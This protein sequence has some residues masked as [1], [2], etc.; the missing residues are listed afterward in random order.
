MGAGG[1]SE[2]PQVS[3]LGGPSEK[4]KL[5]PSDKEELLED[6]VDK[7][8]SPITIH[9]K[10]WAWKG[11]KIESPWIDEYWKAIHKWLND[12]LKLTGGKDHQGEF[13]KELIQLKRYS[14]ININ[15]KDAKD[16]QK[17]KTK[18]DEL[19]DKFVKTDF[20][21][22]DK[23][24]VLDPITA[25][26]TAKW[27]KGNKVQS[28]AAIWGPAEDAIYGMLRSIIITEFPK[29][30]AYK[31]WSVNKDY[32]IPAYKR[33]LKLNNIEPAKAEYFD[34]MSDEYDSGNAIFAD[35]NHGI[36]FS[37][38]RLFCYVLLRRSFCYVL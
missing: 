7:S 23:V 16:Y 14:T 37:M 32:G 31:Q 18:N 17:Y 10:I 5:S 1:S 27:I 33:W 28:P 25:L 19:Y 12:R 3:K 34:V 8:V 24:G 11:K 30:D 26:K 4:D 35:F 6:I 29:S 36:L 13:V 9:K 2:Q 15:W 21:N 20:L 38:L 22:V